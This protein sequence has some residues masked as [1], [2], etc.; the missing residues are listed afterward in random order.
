MNMASKDKP[1]IINV[2]NGISRY[3][4]FQDVTSIDWNMDDFAIRVKKTKPE[5][6]AMFGEF[7]YGD[8]INFICLI[9]RHVINNNVYILV[10]L[11]FVEKNKRKPNPATRDTDLQELF[12]LRDEY[13][14]KN[15]IS[16]ERV[17]DTLFSYV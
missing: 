7:F 4:T 6:F 1:E 2:V 16:K 14:E 11:E 17:P 9:A 12:D 15:G 5:L 10:I 8:F 13:V 3:I